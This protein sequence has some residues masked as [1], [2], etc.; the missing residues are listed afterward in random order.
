MDV[1]A[2]PSRCHPRVLAPSPQGSPLP[3]IS[4]AV[5][6]HLLTSNLK[7]LPACSITGNRDSRDFGRYTDRIPEKPLTTREATI[8][9][10]LRLDKVQP[11]PQYY[12]LSVPDLQLL[13]PII[14]AAERTATSRQTTCLF[15]YDLSISLRRR[16]ITTGHFSERHA[17][18][19]FPRTSPAT[20]TPVETAILRIPAKAPFQHQGSP[21][22]HIFSPVQITPATACRWLFDD[23]REQGYAK[24]DPSSP[25]APEL[26]NKSVVSPRPTRWRPQP[27]ILHPLFP[28]HS[29]K[30]RS[31]KRPSTIHR[32][33][34]SR[35][36]S[37]EPLASGRTSLAARAPTKSTCMRHQ[38]KRRLNGCTAKQTQHLQCRKRNRVRDASLL[39]YYLC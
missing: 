20:D 13:Q 16:L 1:N 22:T 15:F 6:R 11:P 8:A 10:K 37:L 21:A 7:H 3:F 34:H 26:R 14:F 17:V 35:L 24:S 25:L 4:G 9:K 32:G 38:P 5:L 28:I 30:P 39:A 18:F 19:I 27:A 23:R 29:R 36:E 33:L 31:N 2:Q 12:P